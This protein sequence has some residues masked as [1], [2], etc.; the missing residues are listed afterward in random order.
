MLPGWC[1]CCVH[2]AQLLRGPCCCCLRPQLQLGWTALG[3]PCARRRVLLLAL[4]MRGRLQAQQ[5]L[6][7]QSLAW[8]P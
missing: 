8:R 2:R 7:R 4:G 6:P 5:S 3:L 1:G